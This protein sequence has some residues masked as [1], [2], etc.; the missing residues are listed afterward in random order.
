MFQKSGYS[1]TN[2]CNRIII[3]NLLS[4]FFP[5]QTK[6]WNYTNSQMHGIFNCQML[7]KYSLD[8]GIVY[9]MDI[10]P[11]L[12]QVFPEQ[13]PTSNLLPSLLPF[14]N[15][16]KMHWK[17]NVRLNPYFSMYTLSVRQAWKKKKK[18]SLRKR[19]NKVMD[20]LKHEPGLWFLNLHFWLKFPLSVYFPSTHRT[21]GKV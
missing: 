19:M 13:V 10:H 17:M 7:T 6:I 1:S 2:I 18:C 5:N 3:Y 16:E 14:S 8:Q 15:S 4:H 11:W 20:E 21:Q 12:A 9:K